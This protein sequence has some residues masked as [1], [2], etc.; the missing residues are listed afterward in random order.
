MSRHSIGK[1]N[2]DFLAHVADGVPADELRKRWRDGRYPHLHEKL[3]RY[4]IKR[5]GY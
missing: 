3:A 4:A 2:A 5:R 1:G